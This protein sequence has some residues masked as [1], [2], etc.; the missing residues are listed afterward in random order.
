MA[1]EYE[2]TPREN[3]R[4]DLI[5]AKLIADAAAEGLSVERDALLALP[6]V[7]LAIISESAGLPSNYMDEV[8]RIPAVAAQ[9]QRAEHARQMAD[10][11]SEL[12]QSIYSLNRHQRLALGHAMQAAPPEAGGLSAEAEATAIIALRKIADPSTRMTAARAMGIVK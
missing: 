3:A 7:R 5:S 10:S 4:A 8:R 12:S 11:D 6:S 2:L 1:F 9:V